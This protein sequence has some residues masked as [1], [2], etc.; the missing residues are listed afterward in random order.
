MAETLVGV[1]GATSFVGQLVIDQL[2][3]QGIRVFAFS[4]NRMLCNCTNVEWR[5]LVSD[6]GDGG[7]DQYAGKI[8]LW[9]SLAPITAL[10]QYFS[11]LHAWGASKVVVL[12]S[13]SCF[14]KLRSSDKL[15]RA[16]AVQLTQGEDSLQL[17]SAC[18]NIKW[19][20]LRPTIIYG[21][22]KDKNITEISRFINRFGFFPLLGRAEGL[23]QPIHAADVAAACVET[24]LNVGVENRAY[25]ISGAEIVSYREMVKRVFVTQGR[26]AVFIKVPLF[27]F[28]V[29]LMLLSRFPRYRHWT[30]AMAER[31]NCDM[32]FD[33]G[34]ASLDFGFNPRRFVLDSVD[35]V[36]SADLGRLHER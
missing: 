9:I 27:V 30:V 2:V 25:N 7:A 22:A 24:L 3:A 4:R 1:I 23:R 29:A 12:S 6:A 18:N 8:R 33:H 20:I 34:D 26:T 11:L 21:F 5:Q 15:E 10:P 36:G 19:V 31:M 13:T 35:V 14:T 16:V 17:W 32:I 28:K